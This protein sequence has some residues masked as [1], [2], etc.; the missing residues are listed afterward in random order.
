[1]RGGSPPI[2][3]CT[4]WAGS[5]AD[6]VDYAAGLLDET[7]ALGDLVAGTDPQVPVPTCPG[8]TITQLFRHVGRGNRWSAQIVADR[9]DGPLDPREVRGGKPPDDPDGALRW[10]NDGAQLL[11]DAV[12]ATGADTSVWTFIGPQPAGWWIRRRFYEVLVHR[13]DAAI[14][15]GTDFETAPGVAAD[16]LS[17][18]LGLATQLAPGIDDAVHLHATDDGL[19][20]EGEWMIRGKSWS[21]EHGKGAVAL[22]GPVVDLLLITTHRRPVAEAGVEVFGDESLLPTWL[23]GTKL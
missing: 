18:W 11:L 16:A 10:L 2:G 13:A 9:M 14:A 1:M 23:A 17:E 15:A 3:E 12:A 8:W 4:A 21:H 22:R 6:C 20:D 5:Y 7:R 19:G